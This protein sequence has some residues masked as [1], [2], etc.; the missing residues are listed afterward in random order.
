MLFHVVAFVFF[1][2][3][4]SACLSLRSLAYIS[5][6]LFFKKMYNISFSICFLSF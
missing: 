3:F 2:F 1:F 6:A 5:V 4:I